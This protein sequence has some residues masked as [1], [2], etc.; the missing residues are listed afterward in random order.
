MAVARLGRRYPSQGV[1]ANVLVTTATLVND[2]V[3][4]QPTNFVTP[5]FGMQ[6]KKGDLA[7]ASYPKFTLS[8]DTATQLPFTLHSKSTWSDG[9]WK[10]CGVFGRIPTTVA[11]S[12]SITL[13]V[14]TGGTAPAT[15]ALSTATLTGRDLKVTLSGTKN[16]SGDWT[17]SLNTGISDNDDLKVV[18]NGPAG[19]LWRIRQQF[20]QAGANHGQLECYHYVAALQ[21]VSGGLWGIR[22]LPAICQPWMDVSSP[23]LVPV[24]ATATLYDGATTLQA[25]G[26]IVVPFYGKIFG[27]LTTGYWNYTQAGGSSAAETTCR[28]NV[29]KTYLRSTKLI[30]PYDLTVTP[31]AGNTYTYVPQGL[32]EWVDDAG[33]GQLGAGGNH[34]VGTWLFPPCFWRWVTRQSKVEEQTVRVNA[35]AIGQAPYHL[36]R[37]TTGSVPVL[38]NTTY[39]GMGTADP[40]I[41][42]NGN[43][44]SAVDVT[45]PAEGMGTDLKIYGDATHWPNTQYPAYVLTGEPQ[46]FDM[47]EEEAQ[48]MVTERFN[49]NSGGNTPTMRSNVVSGTTYY[50]TQTWGGLVA[51]EDAWGIR[52]TALV[53]GIQ[54]DTPWGEPAAISS[55][56][57]DLNSVNFTCINAFNN[58]QNAANWWFTNGIYDFHSPGQNPMIQS[59]MNH[60]MVQAVAFTYAITEDAN[61]LT[62]LNYLLKYYINAHANATDLYAIIS[63]D[64]RDRTSAAQSTGGGDSA[65]LIT[66][67]ADF[68]TSPGGGFN[69]SASVATN[70]FTTLANANGP[71]YT[72]TVGD[73]VSFQNRVDGGAK[74]SPTNFSDDTWYY[75]RTLTD[76]GAGSTKTFK[77]ATTNSDTD[78]VT[79][80]SDLTNVSNMMYFKFQNVPNTGDLDYLG[81]GGHAGQVRTALYVAKAAGATQTGLD[82]IVTRIGT[83]TSTVDYGSNNTVGGPM[84]TAY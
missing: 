31:S 6:F 79:I 67:W 39:T 77:L 72:L 15:S 49:G 22:W 3:S 73:R 21:D 76:A 59:F 19:I 17:S 44:A 37:S 20:M 40:N 27:A 5:F 33:Q 68:G 74:V 65:N 53:R 38:N 10:F 25:L 13:N 2:S 64:L 58:A 57:A 18:G 16:L 75:V 63:Y 60:Y 61:A 4:T 26:S 47:L 45:V 8:T 36:R 54:P 9:S 82:P 66:G 28:A 30:P 1:L 69:W 23:S 24:T 43:G 48:F 62:F 11:G 7:G 42:W 80:G 35:L 32:A 34:I 56:W 50:A 70:L 52:G 12:G 78:I 83:I 29:D 71:L 81:P 84:V 14:Y 51:R 46:Y 41:F 55:Y